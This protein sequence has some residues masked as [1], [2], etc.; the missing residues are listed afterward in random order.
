METSLF[1]LNALSLFHKYAYVMHTLCITTTRLAVSFLRSMF[2]DIKFIIKGRL[3]K[4]HNAISITLHYMSQYFHNH[5]T[6]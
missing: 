3:M 4:Y 6:I 1:S 2:V 5:T